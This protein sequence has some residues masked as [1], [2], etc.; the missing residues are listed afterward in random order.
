MHKYY[1]NYCE[2]S[3]RL[4]RLSASF[5]LKVSCR[6]MTSASI[7]SKFNGYIK[8]VTRF[9][10]NNF[11]FH[12]C[13]IYVN[14]IVLLVY[15]EFGFPESLLIY[16]C[17]IFLSFIQLT[18]TRCSMLAPC[19]GERYAVSSTGFCSQVANVFTCVVFFC[20]ISVGTLL[21]VCLVLLF[22]TYYVSDQ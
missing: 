19:K 10:E 7:N 17:A 4:S 15:F 3:D 14:K 2:N 5:W 8:S 1:E 13:E 18:F 16:F 22:L 20:V 6:A 11:T 12:I 21:L 9:S